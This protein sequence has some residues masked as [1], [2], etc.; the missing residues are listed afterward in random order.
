M[1]PLESIGQFLDPF[2]SF[3]VSDIVQSLL[4]RVKYHPI[5]ALDLSVGPWMGD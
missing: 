1:Q 2:A 5:G 4:E 3:C